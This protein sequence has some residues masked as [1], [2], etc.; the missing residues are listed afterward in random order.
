SF[1]ASVCSIASRLSRTWWTQLPSGATMQSKPL[2]LRTNNASVSADS[3]LKPLSAIGCPQQVWS[4]GYATSWAEALQK[5]EG[6]DANFREEGVDETGDE[7][8]DTHAWLL[9]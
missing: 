6:R 3:A 4:R 2:K 5:F 7:E 8:P 1:T 9:Q